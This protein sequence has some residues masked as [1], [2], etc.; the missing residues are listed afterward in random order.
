MSNTTNPV[1]R[2]SKVPKYIVSGFQRSAAAWKSLPML[3]SLTPWLPDS[4]GS[5]I[6]AI[7]RITTSPWERPRR[8]A[9]HP[10]RMARKKHRPAGIASKRASRELLPG[11]AYLV[12]VYVG[13]LNLNRLG[14]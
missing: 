10:L 7:T 14:S 4:T 9:A 1:R 6:L 11:G 3:P 13:P 5:V 8:S 2:P 12:A